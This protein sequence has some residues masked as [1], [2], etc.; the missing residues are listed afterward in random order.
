MRAGIRKLP[1]AND[2]KDADIDRL[3]HILANLSK[4]NMDDIESGINKD[5]F[6]SRLAKKCAD[7]VRSMMF[8]ESERRVGYSWIIGKKLA[9]GD[10]LELD[11]LTEN[12][13]PV[14]LFEMQAIVGDAAFTPEQLKER[15]VAALKGEKAMD[16]NLSSGIV[17]KSDASLGY[18]MELLEEVHIQDHVYDVRNHEADDDDGSKTSTKVRR[19]RYAI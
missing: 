11:N 2:E 6:S 7:T 15:R 17:G 5:S 16:G 13:H 8:Q 3:R 9:T 10:A 18:L 19:A 12:L 1:A 14:I 4:G